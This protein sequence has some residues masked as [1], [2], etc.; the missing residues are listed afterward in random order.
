MESMSN[1]S[2]SGKEEKIQLSKLEKELDDPKLFEGVTVKKKQ[3]ILTR[4]A[5]TIF[6]FKQHSGPLPD[7]ETLAEYEGIVSGSANRIITIFED[8][9][10]HRMAL[11]TKVIG[12]QTFQ[13]GAG[14]VFAFIIG[15]SALAG[16]VYCILE[17]HDVAGVSVV[18]GGLLSLAA[19]FLKAKV[20]QQE[21]LDKKKPK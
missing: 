15:M 19:A 3:Q 7:S 12:R 8:Q 4:V 16:G 13:S 11:E 1:N 18:G 5:A 21:D 6:R 17:G 20:S 14:Q 2:L 10:H 9:A